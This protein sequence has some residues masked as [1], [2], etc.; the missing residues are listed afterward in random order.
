M[1]R[2]TDPTALAPAPAPA[3]VREPAPAPGLDRRLLRALRAT[4]ARDGVAGAAR[5]LSL[6]GE[7]GAVWLA[8]G[9]LA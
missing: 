4:G 3:R 7:H 2:T 8:A 1:T 5:G 6:A 9:L